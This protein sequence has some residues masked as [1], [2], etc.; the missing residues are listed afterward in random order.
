MWLASEQQRRAAAVN[1]SY[2]ELAEFFGISK[3]SAQSSVGH[4]IRLKLLIVSQATVTA[5]PRYT[6]RTPWKR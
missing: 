4:L 5:T 1:I 2:D 6:V 3:S